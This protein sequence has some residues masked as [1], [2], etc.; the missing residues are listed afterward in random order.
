MNTNTVENDFQAALA[1]HRSGD[2]QAAV[3]HFR[4]VLDVDPDHGKAAVNLGL[5]ECQLGDFE[6]GLDRLLHYVRRFADDEALRQNF[7]AAANAALQLYQ[8]QGEAGKAL[9][10]LRMMTEVQPGNEMLA[11]VLRLNLHE[12]RERAR[13]SDYTQD[14]TPDKLGRTLLIACMPKSGSTWLHS[15]MQNL[16]GFENC[17]LTYGFMENEQE[18]YLPRVLEMAETDIAVQQHCRATAPNLSIMQAFEFT[19]VVLVGNLFDTLVSM[20]DF[21]A[22]GASINSFLRQHY[23][24]LDAGEQLDAVIDLLASWYVQFVVSWDIADREGAVP[25]HWLSYEDMM[26]DKP[27][28]ITGICSYAGFEKTSDEIAASLA[29]VDAARDRTRFNKGVAGRGETEL[30]AAQKDRVRSL[31]RHFPDTDFSRIGL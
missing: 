27:T 29:Q 24:R 22:R 23:D 6:T 4:Q 1:A 16:T 9:K 30:S 26:A 7:W 3:R 25:V 11:R 18:L 21:Y 12:S 31:T 2:T 13:L 17:F 8:R 28:A 20:R 14:L 10:V 15:V 19:P 5:L